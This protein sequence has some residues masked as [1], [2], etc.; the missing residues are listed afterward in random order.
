MPA[1]TNVRSGR[2]VALLAAVQ[3]ALGTPQTAFAL[4]PVFWTHSTE[5]PVSAEKTEDTWMAE[6][7]GPAPEERTNIGDRPL[8]RFVAAV[9]PGVLDLLLRSNWGPISG[10]SYTLASQINEWLTLAWVEWAAAGNIGRI[11]RVQDAWIPRLVLRAEFPRGYLVAIASYM[12]RRTLMDAKGSGGLTFPGSWSPERNPVT[13]NGA[14]FVR[15]PAGLNVPLRIRELEIT[16]F[17][18]PAPHAWEYGD[19][20]YEVLKAGPTDVRVQVRAEV[21]DETWALI[22]DSRAGTLRQFRFTAAA[23]S[24][25]TTLTLTFNNL[26]FTFEE[27]G[28]DGKDMREIVAD[29]RAH[30][31]AGELATISVT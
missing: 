9:T 24:P 23:Q 7:A 11:V 22:D 26:D 19:L 6:T 10:S 25:A 5:I 4:S 12:G 2:Q 14:A 1:A 16:L 13:V 18:R 15:D 8:G 31:E 27:I 29:G 21:S 30:L 20:L 28:H 17:Q 3:A